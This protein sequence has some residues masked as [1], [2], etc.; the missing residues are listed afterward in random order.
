MQE[1]AYILLVKKMSVYKITE[2]KKILPSFIIALSGC[3]L[4]LCFPQKT[5]DAVRTGIG[6]CMNILVPSLFPFMII[7]AFVSNSGLGYALGKALNKPAKLLFGLNGAGCIALLLGIIGGYP[8][9]GATVGIMYDKGYMNEKQA[10]KAAYMCVCSGP[11]F[12]INFVGASLY[13][14]AETGFLLYLSAVSAVIATG[15]T[16][17]LT[18]KSKDDTVQKTVPPKQREDIAL[19]ITR[20]V[21]QATKS[22]VDMCSAVILFC[23]L[24]N[25]GT[26]LISNYT[27]QK[28]FIIL[29]EVTNACNIL[30]GKE[31]LVLIAFAVGFGGISVHFQIFRALGN[32]KI[33]RLLFFVFRIIQGILTALFTKITLWF[34]PQTV[35]VF[36][37]TQNST[38]VMTSSSFFG[39]LMLIIT[40]VCFLYSLKF[41]K[42]KIGG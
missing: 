22:T 20:S 29:T 33:N 39:S 27:V 14:S 36:S 24:A 18:I 42:N 32:V 6:F 41:N 40:A 2:L 13:S 11:G 38:A 19:S 37:S 4:V 8:V 35:Q 30:C 3:V 26:S 12:L 21:A 16:V 10:E 15:I 23:I 9:G 17:N 31:S 5:A 28:G 25:L 1:I 34:F 7:S